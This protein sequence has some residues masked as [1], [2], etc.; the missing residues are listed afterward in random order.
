MHSAIDNWFQ[1]DGRDRVIHTDNGTIGNVEVL[2]M[3]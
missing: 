1:E 3:E 2:R